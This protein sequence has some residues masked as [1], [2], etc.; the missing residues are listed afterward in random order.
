MLGADV[1][2][3][4]KEIF[5][6]SFEKMKFSFRK[7]A[8]NI[9]TEKSTTEKDSVQRISALKLERT[10]LRMSDN[11]KLLEYPSSPLSGPEGL[12]YIKRPVWIIELQPGDPFYP[13][14]KQILFVDK[15]TLKPSFK[16][17]YTR[18]GEFLK[19]VVIGWGSVYE[20]NTLVPS[21]YLPLYQL[22]I[23][24]TLEESIIS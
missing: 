11:N 3:V 1:V 15:S 5:I 7:Q 20:Q 17:V 9:A 18:K 2:V 21:D 16:I 12:I 4:E 10:D 22:A 6:P 24:S 13:S 14:G 23:Y 8:F 19:L